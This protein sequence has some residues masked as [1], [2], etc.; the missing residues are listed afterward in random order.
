MTSKPHKLSSSFASRTVFPTASLLGLTFFCPTVL[1]AQTAYT[2]KA[3]FIA[4]LG[5]GSLVITNN[6]DANQPGDLIPSGTKICQG[7]LTYNILTADGE[8]LDLQIFD[9]FDTT[10]PL[11]YIGPESPEPRRALFLASDSVMLTFDQP[12]TAIGVQFVAC[13]GTF[14][15]SFHITAI[16]G[17]TEFTADSG[18]STTVLSDWSEPYFVGIIADPG[19]TTSEATIWSDEGLFSY[20][21]DEII[22]QATIPAFVL[23]D[24]NL[25]GTT[26]VLDVPAFVDA[27]LDS[28]TDMCDVATSDLN[29]DGQVNGND[30]QT[31]IELIT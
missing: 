2:D 9:Y 25:D 19:E 8:P 16:V 13:P 7:L 11:N 17:G 29:I 22:F 27:L 28:Y 10:T 31:F 5:N 4:A 14:E 21:L 20:S 24:A 3:A 23:G 15:A 26:D 12:V 30:V 6:W 18:P 1:L